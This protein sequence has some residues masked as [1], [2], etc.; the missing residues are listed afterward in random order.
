MNVLCHNNKGITLIEMMIVVAILAIVS[1]IA[2]PAYTGYITTSRTGECA[3]E[4]AA[5]RLAEE[6]FILNNNVY[7]AGTL[8][9]TTADVLLQDNLVGLYTAS[10]T[11][12]GPNTNCTYAVV[13]AGG[14]YTITATGVNNLAGEGVVVNINGP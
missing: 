14:G 9:G 7:I 13:L 12:A 2:V 1:A 6:E 10:A 8:D 11:A 4:V 3:N 5:I